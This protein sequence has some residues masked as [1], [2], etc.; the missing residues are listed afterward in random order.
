MNTWKS[1]IREKLSLFGW[2]GKLCG[3]LLPICKFGKYRLPVIILTPTP[4]GE[5]WRKPEYGKCLKM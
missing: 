5:R 3:N 4:R 2:C 1:I